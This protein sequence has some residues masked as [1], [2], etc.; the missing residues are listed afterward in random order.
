MMII[1]YNNKVNI[2]QNYLQ[3]KRFQM[4]PNLT[5]KNNHLIKHFILLLRDENEEKT[6]KCCQIIQV[7]IITRI[8]DIYINI[9]KS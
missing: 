8:I 1:K 3:K 6:K 2:Y 5:R 7:E 4:R 9:Y